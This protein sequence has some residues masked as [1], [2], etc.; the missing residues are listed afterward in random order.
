LQLDLTI[1]GW[2]PATRPTVR[3]TELFADWIEAQAFLAGPG[4]SV[5]KPDLV[6]RLEGTSLVKDN[7]D[8][9][10]FVDDAFR[11]CRARRRQ[12]GDAYPF[13]VAGQSI[14]YESEERLP[15]VFCLLVSLPEQLKGLRKAYPADFR[16]IFEGL[17][18][19]AMR[20]TLPGWEVHPTGWSSIAEEVGKGAIVNKVGTWA[21]AKSWDE[22]VF[23]NA[24]DA[25]VDIA[26]VRPFGDARSA[27]PIILGQCATG[28]TDWKS[29]ASRPNLDRW[30]LAV[31]FSSKP[32][33][34]FAVPFALDAHSFWEATVECAGLV[35]DRTR[36]CLKLPKVS[37]G[38]AEQI[39]EWLGQ[40]KAQL[41]IAA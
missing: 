37:D 38:L 18:V 3:R 32:M 23:P 20:A 10:T 34:L 8:A 35:L 1:V 7:D 9:W 27:F 40:A 12:L 33:K 30:S 15:Y 16:N 5:S 4:I 17:V 41:P 24:N 29:K 11:V 21:L 39:T 13:A 31:Q 28:V 36:L 19:E 22:T 25:Q 14:E 26:A 2:G 6:D